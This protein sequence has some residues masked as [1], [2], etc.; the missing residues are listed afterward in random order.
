M[1]YVTAI[2]SNINRIRMITSFVFS[3]AC[4]CEFPAMQA[5]HCGLR[6]LRVAEGKE[7]DAY[8]VKEER[9]WWVCTS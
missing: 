9:E 5:V 3:R 1:T 7:E 4:V 8:D 2:N 6:A